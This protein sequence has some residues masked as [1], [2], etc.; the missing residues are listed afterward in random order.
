[1]QKILLATTLFVTACAANPATGGK[2]FTL[3]GEQSEY[4][5]GQKT[6]EEAMK[7][8]GIYREKPSL[9][10]YIQNLGNRMWQNTERSGQPFQTMILDDE[11]FNAWAT[12]GY[13]NFYRGI[14]PFFQNETHL[15]EV[16]AHEMGHITARHTAQGVTRGTLANLLLT[17]ASI[18]VA[19][20]ADSP[21]TANL[22]ML[23]GSVGVGATLMSF[24]RSQEL[25]ADRL[26]LR[27]MAASGYDP[28]ESY[29][30]NKGFL[31]YEAYER[32]RLAD[33]NGGSVPSG[34][35]LSALMRSHPQTP[36]RIEQVEKLVG[37]PDGTVKLPVGV[38]PATT[39]A[40]PF[41]EKRYLSMIDGISYGPKPEFGIAGKNKIYFPKQRF[42]WNLPTTSAGGFSLVLEDIDEKDKTP[43]WAAYNP[44][45]GDHIMITFLPMLSGLNP[46]STLMSKYTDLRTGGNWE[47]LTVGTGA[48]AQTASTATYNKGGYTYRVIGVPVPTKDLLATILFR[49]KTGEVGPHQALLAAT[50]S[51]QV[52][53]EAK[54]KALQPTRIKVATAR[55]GER[56]STLAA[57]MP[58]TRHAELLF[59]AM[60]GLESDMQTLPA[61]KMYK[62]IVDPNR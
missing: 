1:M 58:V 27:Y 4:A 3:V 59:R 19:A 24:N 43:T 34:G 41:G 18:Y 33:K 20:T 11:T 44:A 52:L 37:K 17:G 57:Q 10:T 55:G 31:L 49:S 16:M 13:V 6:A 51:S 61:G 40:D 35:V 21:A 26:A 48:T 28:R 54:A 38:Q 60:N 47:K 62:T 46:Q 36:D 39:A 23:A 32:A 5:M 22:A 2:N 8:I 45:A 14:L 53:S 30:S 42:I 56:I 29:N 7:E 50:T 9:N 25:E 12:P 15:A